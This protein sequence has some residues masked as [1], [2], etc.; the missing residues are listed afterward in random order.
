MISPGTQRLLALYLTCLLAL[1]A[2]GAH[3]QTR[4]RDHWRLMEDK[5]VLQEELLGLRKGAAEVAGALAVRRWAHA[6]GMVPAPEVAEQ[7][8]VPPAPPPETYL[9]QGGLE[10]RT[11]WR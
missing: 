5:G 9:P 11:V 6:R 10:V 1:A 3:N 7:G 8:S 2:L 4:Y